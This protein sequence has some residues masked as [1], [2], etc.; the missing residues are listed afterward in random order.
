MSQKTGIE[1]TDAT[2]NPSTGCTKVSQ[3]CKNCYALRD[4]GRLSH[5]PGTVYFGRDFTDVQVHPDRLGDPFGWGRPRRIFVNSMSD[6]FHEEIPDDFIA[7]VLAVAHWCP[8]HQFQILTKRAG[9]M[10]AFFANPETYDRLRQAVDDIGA[11]YTHRTLW[12][13][14]PMLPADNVWLGVSVEDQET[15]VERIPALLETPARIRFLSC[16]PLLGSI[17]LWPWV[18]QAIDATTLESEIVVT[19]PIDW[20]I[21]GGESGPKARPTQ[22]AWVR[23]IRDQCARA[24]VPFFFKQWG[25]WAPGDKAMKRVGKRYA[26]ASLDGREHR[27]WP[28]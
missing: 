22:P 16:E 18:H 23:A 5:N 25:E 8:H 14:D 27:E 15:A 9:R 2:W 19:S 13:P 1:W 24:R 4:W 26:G 28:Q 21:A 6:L 7:Q 20:V 12:A 3:G 10:A 17:D 11:Q